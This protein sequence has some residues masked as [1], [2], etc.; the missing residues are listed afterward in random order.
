MFGLPMIAKRW[1]LT[2]VGCLFL[3]LPMACLAMSKAEA[4][5]K[6][7]ELGGAFTADELADMLSIGDIE[8]AR[9]YLI[10]G[11]PVTAKNKDGQAM[12]CPDMLP[13]ESLAL[14]IANGADPNTKCG[15]LNEPRIF[16]DVLFTGS[17]AIPNIK[18]LLSKGVNINA[19]GYDG[20]T[21]LHRAAITSPEDTIAFLLS[22]GAN[23]NAKNDQGWT[24]LHYA[25]AHSS[26]SVVKLLVEKGASLN[27]R[28]DAT[29]S[30][31]NATPFGVALSYGVRRKDI[32]E[33]LRSKGAIQ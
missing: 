27:V 30:T 8:V 22:Q 2:L 9:L 3:L 10:A 7:K 14:L 5:Q 24:P 21:P 23:I 32:A 20:R 11:M 6:I 16:M 4:L 19:K 33:Y 28:G 18:L 17:I 31:P 13:P 29:M 25:A 26:L 15:R 1:T 12:M